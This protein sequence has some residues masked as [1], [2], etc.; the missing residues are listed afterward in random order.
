MVRATW[1][2]RARKIFNFPLVRHFFAMLDS[3][4]SFVTTDF[5]AGP[6]SIPAAPTAMAAG[7]LLASV[8]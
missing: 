7:V 6:P 5:R 4:L 2:R 1:I 3:N 8:H